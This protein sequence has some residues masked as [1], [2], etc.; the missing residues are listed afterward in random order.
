MK[1]IDE[2]CE[3]LRVKLGNIDN[4]MS[5]L[6]T[7][8]SGK[9]PHAEQEVRKHLDKIQTHIIQQR[10]KISA[11]QA[12]MKNWAEEKEAAT[13][14][15]IAEWKTKHDVS[16]LKTRAEKAERYFAAAKEMAMAAVD[17]AEQAALEAW[18]ARHEADST[19]SK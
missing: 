12:E 2:F 1:R 3:D 16:R 19:R 6:K 17:E 15:K 9:A 8:I 5:V 10:A 18:L 14:V 4:N 7:K 13:S 11:A